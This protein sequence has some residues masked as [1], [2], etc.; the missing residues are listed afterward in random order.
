MYK[1]MDKR[2][3][4]VDLHCSYLFPRL[5]DLTILLLGDLQHWRSES[6]LTAIYM[7][8]YKLEAFQANMK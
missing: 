7:S 6:F 3:A 1:V 2:L 8:C 5:N 4:R